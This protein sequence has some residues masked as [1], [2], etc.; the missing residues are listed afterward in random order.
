[1]KVIRK[2][3]IEAT[4]YFSK[5]V[6][7]GSYSAV[8]S[9]YDI[10]INT[11]KNKIELL[12]DYLDLKLTK[13]ENNRI[14]PTDEGLKFYH[15]CKEQLKGL[16]NAI[17]NV[18]DNGFEQREALKILGTSLFL[19]MLINNVLPDI[20]KISKKPLNIYLNSYL[21]H[22]LNGREYNLDS[23]SI[24]EIY[25]NDLQYIDLDRWI[26]CYSVDDVI[27]PAHIYGKKDFVEQFHNSPK[28]LLKANMIYHDYDF[29]LKKVKS[30]Y[31]NSLYK[32]NRDKVVYI[33]NTDSQKIPVLMND[34]VLTIM[35]EYC[36]E[37][38]VSDFSNIKK[39]EGFEIDY[40][41]ESHM[42]LV[43]RS[44]PYKR[45]LIDIIRSGVKGIRIKYDKS[46]KG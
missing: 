42:I 20:R 30:L 24:I 23:Y 32:L 39:V 22:D 5:L 40:P 26:I 36:Y 44:S 38:L 19:R 17:I 35:S 7:L 13:P 43:N 8:K 16:E 4:R 2:D 3:I 9:Y 28:E 34:N 29:N 6:E 14:L 1:M 21:N 45:E 27:I 10:Q 11:V 46:F 12:E 18:K 41:V 15:S 31:D 33:A 37:T 25:E